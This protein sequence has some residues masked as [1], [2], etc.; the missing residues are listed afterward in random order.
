MLRRRFSALVSRKRAKRLARRPPVADVL[1]R[2]RTR[3]GGAE[4]EA[5]VAAV[6][7]GRDRD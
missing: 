2:A 6:R 7:A 1:A 3:P 4:H 5:I